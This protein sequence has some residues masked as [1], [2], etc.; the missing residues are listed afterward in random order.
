MAPSIGGEN[1]LGRV[2]D[3]IGVRAIVRAHAAVYMLLVWLLQ[4]VP[5]AELQFRR[6]FQQTGGALAT[7]FVPL[8]GLLRWQCQ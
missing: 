3:V 2:H 6:W 5:L 8:V 1:G 7:R 4:L